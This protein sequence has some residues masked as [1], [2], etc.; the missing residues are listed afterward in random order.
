MVIKIRYK[1][2]ACAVLFI[3]FFTTI[4]AI[5]LNSQPE[6]QYE[7]TKDRVYLPII[8]YHQIKNF[9]T[10]K[11][12]ITPYEF[13]SDLK[14]LSDNHY[15]TIT[16]TQL[17]DFVSNNKSLPENPIIL[18]FDDGYLNTYKY[19]LPLLEKYKMKIVLSVIGKDLDNYSKIHCNDLDYSHI[20]WT[21]LKEMIDSGCVEVQNHSY[22][23]HSESNGR[24]GCRKKSSESIDEYEK[25]LSA[26]INKLQV[27]LKTITGCVPNTYA[28]PFGCSSEETAGIIKKTGLKA[29]LSV[30]YGINIIDKNNPEVLYGLRRIC[31]AHGYSMEKLIK[32][33]Y[34]TLKYRKI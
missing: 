16:V 25:A 34:K 2:V 33:V 13:E 28:Y 24:V 32:D 9:N 31:R 5:G 3:L 11:N 23:M 1:Y 6:I 30:K 14:Y 20:T 19:A 18:S 29:T 21:Q 10:G 12:T 4:S 26:D 22:D 8:M 17:I 15:N 27:K 7:N